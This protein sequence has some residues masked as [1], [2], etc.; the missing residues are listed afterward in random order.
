MPAGRESSH[1]NQTAP[2]QEQDPVEFGNWA[3]MSASRAGPSC[4]WHVAELCIVTTLLGTHDR[5][6]LSQEFGTWKAILTL[7]A[8]WALDSPMCRFSGHLHWAGGGETLTN[9][10]VGPG[11][12]HIF[13]CLWVERCH[14]KQLTGSCRAGQDGPKELTTAKGLKNSLTAEESSSQANCLPE[15]TCTFWQKL[16]KVGTVQIH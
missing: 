11:Q 8:F 7:M 13:F 12:I 10:S 3:R 15:H 2:S 5:R 14:G 1:T 6:H 4:S 9:A 16:A